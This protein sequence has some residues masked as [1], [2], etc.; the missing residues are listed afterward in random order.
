MRV[1][2]S[3]FEKNGKI[4]MIYWKTIFARTL[5]ILLVG[6]RN[7]DLLKMLVTGR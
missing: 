4:K 6:L 7:E 5:L 1:P 3:L 2:T